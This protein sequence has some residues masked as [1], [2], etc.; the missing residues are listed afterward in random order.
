M[1]PKTSD[2]V[3]PDMVDLNIVKNREFMDTLS[4]VIPYSRLQDDFS[5]TYYQKSIKMMLISQNCR[6]A[7]EQ[8]DISTINKLLNESAQDGITCSYLISAP[9]SFGKTTAMHTIIKRYLLQGKTAVPYV[10]LSRLA[11]LRL[12][13]EKYLKSTL[14]GYPAEDG[15]I[16]GFT[17]ADWLNADIVAVKLTD[18]EAATVESAMLYSLLSHRGEKNLPTL[19]TTDYTIKPYLD[20]KQLKRVYWDNILVFNEAKPSFDRVIYKN[21]YKQYI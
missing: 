6:L 21:T 9:N 2:T 7:R 10:S 15:N 5:L 17:W 3:M 1:Q 12:K 20:N 11:E 4:K 18:F 16:N 19:V 14:W 13:H 8:E